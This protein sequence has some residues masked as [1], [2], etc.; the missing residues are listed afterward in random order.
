MSHGGFCNNCDRYKCI[1]VGNNR[2]ACS[3]NVCRFCEIRILQNSMAN[4]SL[5]NLSLTNLSLTNLSLINSP[6]TLT[7][8]ER[9]YTPPNRPQ[10]RYRTLNRGDVLISR[11]QY[12]SYDNS[13]DEENDFIHSYG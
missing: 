2:N 3:C 1:C 11:T 4:L 9:S 8:E 10:T 13:D 5:I 7:S 12:T 6:G